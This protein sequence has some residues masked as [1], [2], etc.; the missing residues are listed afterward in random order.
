MK[1][2]INSEKFRQIIVTNHLQYFDD[3]IFVVLK[4]NQPIFIVFPWNIIKQINK[5]FSFEKITKMDYGELKNYEISYLNPGEMI[6]IM[7]FNKPF[8]I[9][10]WY[11]IRLINFIDILLNQINACLIT[12]TLIKKV[13]I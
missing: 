10:S 4:E 11:D 7:K 3:E 8:F 13:K 12:K 2:E 5:H 1:N 9:F 6:K